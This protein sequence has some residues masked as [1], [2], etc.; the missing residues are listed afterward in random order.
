MPS[1]PEFSSIIHPI[2]YPSN[3][4]TMVSR[5]A[6]PGCRGQHRRGGSRR[7]FH[8]QTGARNLHA[9]RA[10]RYRRVR[11]M[12]L[13]GRM[14]EA[15]ADQLSRWRGHQNQSRLPHRPPRYRGRGPGESLRQRY[16]GARRSAAI[17]PGL[18]RDRD[19]RCRRGRAGGG[20]PG[21][22]LPPQRVRADRRG[23]RRDARSL[24]AG[25]I[26]PGGLHRGRS[27]AARADRRQAHSRGRRAPG[28]ALQRAAHQRL[29][30]GAQA[31]VR[32]GRVYALDRS[33]GNGRNGGRCAAPGA[34]QLS[35]AD[36][37]SGGERPA[38]GRGAHHRWRPHGQHAAHA[39]GRAGRG[40]RYARLDHPADFRAPAAAGQP[41]GRRLP[42]HVQSR[43]RDDSGGPGPSG[44]PAD[45][46]R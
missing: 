12:L 38:A 15:G 40:D 19:A 26:R 21:A 11:R 18:F 32:S 35:E 45:A 23:D 2:A 44:Q 4:Y 41:A 13:A 43:H 42:A 1:R 31:A 24:R 8:T 6:L 27:R 30:A 16:R 39:A 25:R 5:H 33:A 46:P 7:L 17:L 29:L 22:R 34:S 10:D 14:E 37:R 20:G 3:R 36:S 9:R 28:P